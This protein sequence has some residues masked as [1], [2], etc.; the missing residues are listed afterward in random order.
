MSILFYALLLYRTLTLSLFLSRSGGEH[1]LVDGYDSR[2]WFGWVYFCFIT[3]IFCALFLWFK[4]KYF[5][6]NPMLIL[7]FLFRFW[8]PASI[9][10]AHLGRCPVQPNI[11]IYLIVLG[12]ASLLSLSLTYTMSTTGDQYVLTSTCMTLL[13][14]FTFC[15]LIAGGRKCQRNLIFIPR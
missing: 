13:H 15:W 9:G 11:P 1:Y 8:T 7:A 4:K 12:L 2:H 3:V 5:F 14:L 6:H 10:A